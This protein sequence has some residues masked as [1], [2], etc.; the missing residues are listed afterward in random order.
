MWV[1]LIFPPPPAPYLATVIGPTLTWVGLFE[2]RLTISLG[3]KVNRGNNFS[4]VKA[5]SIAYVKIVY[6]EITHAENWRKKI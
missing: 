4:Y 6:F 5:L 2:S 1:S 3:L